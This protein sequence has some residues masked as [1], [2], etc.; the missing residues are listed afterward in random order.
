MSLRE[1]LR[2]KLRDAVIDFT[3]P[4]VRL[5]LIKLSKTEWTV[6][7]L[8]RELRRNIHRIRINKMAFFIDNL[9]G[10]EHISSIAEYLP[11]GSFDIILCPGG[12][13]RE[14]QIFNVDEVR[15]KAIESLPVDCVRVINEVAERGDCYLLLVSCRTNVGAGQYYR[16]QFGVSL[17]AEH[18]EDCALGL[19]CYW[20]SLVER[21]G[22][23]FDKVFCFSS[24]QE[25]HLKSFF[26]NTKVYVTGN[27]RFDGRLE[28]TTRIDRSSL[29]FRKKTILFLPIHTIQKG[30]LSALVAG[31]QTFSRDY[32]VVVGSYVFYPE[33]YERMKDVIRSGGA[34]IQLIINEDN[35][36]LMLIADFVF[37][38]PYGGSILTAVRLDKNIIVVVYKPPRVFVAN[39]WK[40]LFESVAD[41]LG[42]FSLDD[43][44]KIVATLKDDAYWERQRVVR[45]ELR[46][47][48]FSFHKEPSGKLIADEL[49][50]DLKAASECNVKA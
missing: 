45:A 42:T 11:K 40:R 19:S 18:I 1:N 39:K 20:M 31:A 17:I 3:Y 35:V 29:D 25:N 6:W 32:N 26:P 34:N 2:E 14:R 41:K 38:D 47:Q 7:H 13:L 5:G 8:K 50:R 27:P 48:F 10:L 33:E 9:L 21:V 24:V 23:L 37:C 36:K 44:D 28:E 12:S 16:G 30:A 49:M 15:V 43:Y 46:K 4:L 22:G